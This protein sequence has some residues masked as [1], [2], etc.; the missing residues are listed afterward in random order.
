MLHIFERMH[1]RLQ[2]VVA[3]MEEWRSLCT[4]I[5][6]VIFAGFLYHYYL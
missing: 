2:K 4:V 5:L 6:Q 3:Y 1:Q